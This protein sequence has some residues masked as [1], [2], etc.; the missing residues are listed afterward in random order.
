M[1]LQANGQLL[2]HVFSYWSSGSL[3]DILSCACW[4]HDYAYISSED[5]NLKAAWHWKEAVNLEIANILHYFKES[6][7]ITYFMRRNENVR[8]CGSTSHSPWPCS[9]AIWIW[10]KVLLSC[11]PAFKENTLCFWFCIL[12]WNKHQTLNGRR[13]TWVCFVALLLII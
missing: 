10:Q 7:K 8:A 4:G 11:I 12:L 9:H 2:N 1:C 3:G 13:S 5:V 6:L